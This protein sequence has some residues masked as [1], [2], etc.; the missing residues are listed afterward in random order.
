M[1]NQVTTVVITA[2]L[3]NPPANFVNTVPVID[4][5]TVS[6]T[7]IAPGG[8]VTANVK[9]HDDQK[10]DTLTFTWLTSAPAPAPAGSL[11]G[12]S[13]TATTSQVTLTAPATAGD[14]TLTIQVQDNH[15]ATA[16][17]SIVIDVSTANANGT[18]QADV[19]AAATSVASAVRSAITRIS[20][21]PAGRS[22]PTR[23]K[24]CRLASAT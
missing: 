7:N 14:V 1:Q 19:N 17:A 9:A 6:S 20:V 12:Q 10:N 22:M 4:S 21:G 13:D 2:Q 8:T 18:G 11:A 5:L 24:S 23:P 16:S 3:V 15:G